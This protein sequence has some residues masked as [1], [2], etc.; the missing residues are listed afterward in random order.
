M[1][2]VAR[3]SNSF[4][5]TASQHSKLLRQQEMAYTEIYKKALSGA[6][7]CPQTTHLRTSCKP[8]HCIYSTMRTSQA[9]LKSWRLVILKSCTSRIKRM[10]WKTCL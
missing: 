4:L 5:L 6:E 2:S 7:G 3:P 8:E 9:N 10:I 1:D